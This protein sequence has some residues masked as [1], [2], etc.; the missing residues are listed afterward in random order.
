LSGLLFT[1]SAKAGQDATVIVPKGTTDAAT[2]RGKIRFTI[3]PQSLDG[4]LADFGAIS[5]MEVLYSAKLTTSKL[6]S[7]ITGLFTPDDALR[8]LL[9]ET[10]LIAVQTSPAAIMLVATE[11]DASLADGVPSSG[12]VLRLAPLQITAP[13]SAPLDDAYIYY[14][15]MLRYAIRDAL[16]QNPELGR[17]QTRAVV[18]VWVSETGAVRRSDFLMSTGDSDLDRRIAMV[19]QNVSAGQ[20]PPPQ[21]PQPVHVWIRL[22]NAASFSTKYAWMGH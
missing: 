13:S 8:R 19:V 7:G 9:K 15:K 11:R 4:A 5:R 3:K 20:A 21:M 17:S 22:G 18:N 10:D 14:A 1:P 12:P 2:A 6:S 16:Q